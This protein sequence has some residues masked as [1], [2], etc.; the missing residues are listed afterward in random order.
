MRVLAVLLLLLG[1]ALFWLSATASGAGVLLG[2]VGRLAPGELHFASQTGALADLK[3]SGLRY[4]DAAGLSVRCAEFELSWHPWAL[5]RGRL[6]IERL[7]A[8]QVEVRLP[9]STGEPSSPPPSWSLPMAVEVDSALIQQLE[10][11]P[12]EGE[13][14]VVDE[15][16]F[17]LAGRDEQLQVD[18]LRLLAA[19]VEAE[20]Q[21]ELHAQQVDFEVAWTVFVEGGPKLS[22]G[23]RIEGDPVRLKI[24]QQLT[25]QPGLRLAAQIEDA[26][27]TAALVGALRFDHFDPSLT[28]PAWPAAVVTGELRLAGSVSAPRL[29]LALD[30]NLAQAEPWRLSGGVA[31]AADGWRLSQIEMQQL[32]GAGWLRADGSLR[33]AGSTMAIDLALDWRQLSTSLAEG[34]QLLSPHGSGRLAGTLADYRLEVLADLR[35]AEVE[36]ADWRL[37]ATGD[38]D[39][40]LIEELGGGI[41]GGELRVQGEVAWQP[42]LSW[43][44][45]MVATALDTEVLGPQW[46]GAAD[47]RAEVA[48]YVDPTGGP[49]RGTLDLEHLGGNLR[50]ESLGGAGRL[51][52]DG[53]ALVAEEL[54]LSWGAARLELSGQ[55]SAG[56]DLE[57]ELEAPDLAPLWPDTAGALQASGRLSGAWPR[58]Q[59]EI[60]ARASGLRWSD[61]SLA[62]FDLS[63]SLQ[64]GAEGVTEGRLLL[65]DLRLR[66]LQ[67]EEADMTLSG[68]YAAHQLAGLLRLPLGDLRWRAV[69]GF[70]THWQG[71]FEALDAE[72][73]DYGSWRLAAP[74]ELV[75]AAEQSSLAPA[76]WHSS[77]GKVCLR[78][79]SVATGWQAS[80]Q[81][82]ALDLR[83]LSN[84]LP[85]GL[86]VK[87]HFDGEAEASSAAA[88]GWL[89]SARLVPSPG[90]FEYRR[91]GQET[92]RFDYAGGEL[93]LGLEDGWLRATA[94]LSFAGDDYLRGRF[95]M[96]WEQADAEIEGDLEARLSTLELVPVL[97]PQLGN[98]AGRLRIESQLAG[99]W[100]APRVAG[101][102]TLEEGRF[103]LPDFGIEPRDVHLR[104]R[105]ET[106]DRWLIS[107][108]GTSGGG[109]LNVAGEAAADFSSFSLRLTG[110]DFL[111]SDTAELRAEVSPRLDLQ[112][113]ARELTFSGQVE[114]PRAHLDLGRQQ[115]VV[116]VA[117]DVVVLGGEDEIAGLPL[118]GRL[119]VIFGDAVTVV[120][121]GADL[122]ATGTLEIDESPVTATTAVGELAIEEGTYKI[123]GQTLKLADS[124]LTFTGGPISRPG[125]DLRAV[126][127][128]KDGT[129]AV[130]T[131]QGSAA[132]PEVK[133]TTEPPT[134]PSDSL[135]YLVLGR[136]LTSARGADNDLVEQAAASLGL[137][138]GGLAAGK[139]A[140]RLG[141]DDAEIESRGTVEDSTFFVGK[142]LSPRLYLAYG[143]GIFRPIG[144]FRARYLVDRH[145]TLQAESG[146]ENG[147]DVLYRVDR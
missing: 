23:G 48:G 87:G 22:G 40:L 93:R 102:L 14:S 106:G 144:V 126:R 46:P 80:L 131:A 127:E 142:Y 136:P 98:A 43:R 70:E 138:L 68:S 132:A 28:D 12:A 97:I 120:G 108:A 66:E 88:G 71:R 32:G 49:A 96:P 124:R 75:L 101:L 44:L 107:G 30:G 56:L 104:L 60:E 103:A 61:Y 137:G 15:L 113:S 109:Q 125:L 134:S 5:L 36:L 64:P 18:T 4:H 92:V 123:Y 51:L 65:H 73:G 35:L 25:S 76:C 95:A 41:G 90:G 141:F 84:H 38:A 55:L 21:G 67:L 3:I 91:L 135:A 33:P 94:D 24:T 62:R 111:L 57:F 52:F 86:R 83:L 79:S 82:E 119:R 2:W 9:P 146:E 140:R 8:R 17:A 29:E 115:S 139:L 19:G 118:A 58:P 42:R 11:V 39:R 121:Y 59:V 74:A 53:A 81:L 129:V 130:L 85:A 116:E 31:L 110:T 13:S 37:A 147:V 26:F 100:S 143:V 47:L 99:T 114:V 128:A 77:A 6:Q 63:A 34:R 27:D 72:F 50:G 7:L 112:F 89:G 1:L 122:R 69:G 117:D 133:I 16:E 45:G 54:S 145:W 20:L 10:V 78:G 105:S